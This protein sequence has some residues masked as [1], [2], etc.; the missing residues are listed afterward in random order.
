MFKDKILC[1]FQWPTREEWQ[2]YLDH[3]IYKTTL[4]FMLAHILILALFYGLMYY[5][6]NSESTSITTIRYQRIA[7]EL[8]ILAPFI[9][10]VLVRLDVYRLSPEK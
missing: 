2:R 8:S 3:Y 6:L 7:H 4:N 9:T 1:L 10:Y 5:V